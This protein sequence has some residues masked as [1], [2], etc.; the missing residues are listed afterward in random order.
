MSIVL[1]AKVQEQKVAGY[2]MAPPSLAVRLPISADYIKV[3]E[4]SSYDSHWL[5]AAITTEI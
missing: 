1:A 3:D 4:Q 5:S 2:G